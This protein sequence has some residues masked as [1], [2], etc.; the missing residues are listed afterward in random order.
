MFV[1]L[2]SSTRHSAPA[3]L[4]TPL[5]PLRLTRLMKSYCLISQIESDC[6]VENIIKRLSDTI[7]LLPSFPSR[8]SYEW[9]MLLFL[10]LPLLSEIKIK[11]DQLKRL[12]WKKQS[13]LCHLFLVV[14]LNLKK[15]KLMFICKRFE[16]ACKKSEVATYTNYAGQHNKT[17]P[18]R[19]LW[20]LWSVCR[21][22]GWR[23]AL[24]LT[25]QSISS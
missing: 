24:S 9:V 18:G 17:H 22:P 2:A 23:P 11:R 12:L 8:C 25:N 10:A 14:C 16:G 7:H 20:K 13:C 3:Q 1:L 6:A 4:P 21:V 15:A 19:L 5:K